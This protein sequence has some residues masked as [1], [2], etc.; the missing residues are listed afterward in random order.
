MRPAPTLRRLPL[1]LL[2]PL[3]AAV[4]ACSD[5]GPDEEAFC[6]RLASFAE[7]AEAAGD[8]DEPTPEEVEAFT[9]LAESAPGEVREDF[10]IA[11]GVLE[12]F[13]AIDPDADPEDAM[14]TAFA[15]LF[16]P[17]VAEAFEAIEAYA[18]D[19]CGLEDFESGVGDGSDGSEASDPGT[20]SGDDGF[21]DDDDDGIPTLGVAEAEVEAL[22][23]EALGTEPQGQ[24]R[25]RSGSS[26]SLDVGVELDPD[27][28]LAACEE[29]SAALAAHP[30]ADGTAT[31]SL[32]AADDS[33]L[34]LAENEDLAP[35]EPGTCTTP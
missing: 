2:V 17:R 3:L 1:L 28:A 27:A 34:V 19:T 16:N 33:E 12:E 9:A 31:I 15:L 22:V 25:F 13:T 7:E 11:A 35:G 20:G 5:D 21:G 6:D 23:V 4:P 8:D 26:S 10:E 32:H 18:T 30:D 29:L 14:G 24:S